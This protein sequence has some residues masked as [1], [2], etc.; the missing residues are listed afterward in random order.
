M[1]SPVQKNRHRPHG[2]DTYRIGTGILVG[3]FY[4]HNSDRGASTWGPQSVIDT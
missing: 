4:I 1:M 2:R 3:V